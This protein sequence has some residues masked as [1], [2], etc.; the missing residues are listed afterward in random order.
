MHI[1]DENDNLI[2]AGKSTMLFKHNYC[3]EDLGRLEQDI[4]EALDPKFNPI[5][6]GI[7]ALFK[8]KIKITLEYIEEGG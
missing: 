4:S 2:K 5:T 6:A 1:T 7:P 8:G 3:W